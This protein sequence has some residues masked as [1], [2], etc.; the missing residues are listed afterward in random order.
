MGIDW[1]IVLGAFCGGLALTCWL[2]GRHRLIQSQTRVARLL[3]ATAIFAT[4]LAVSFFTNASLNPPSRHLAPLTIAPQTAVSTPP[5]LLAPP[6]VFVMTTPNPQPV[7]T[8]I[9]AEKK[10]VNDAYLHI[11][12]LSV[13]QPII[14][15]PLQ[16]GRWDVSTLGEQVGRLA[17]TGTHP[18][19]KLAPVFAGHMTFPTSATLETGAFANLQY[20]T[21]GTELIYTA[22][23]QQFTYKITEISRVAPSE[24][25][26]L[27]LEDE[28][29]I[30]LVTCTDWDENGRLYKNRLLIRAVQNN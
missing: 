13:S 26:R 27:Y 9:A 21:Y 28:N 7:F 11:P 1:R 10:T 30:L 17:T 12:S 15:L 25:E 3:Q 6:S 29:S 22:N 20:A 18:G 24:V 4:V 19:D 2:E 14:E 16:N 8:P 23:G 5:S